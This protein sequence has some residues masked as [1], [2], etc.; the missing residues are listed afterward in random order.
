M[1]DFAAFKRWDVSQGRHEA[2]FSLIMRSYLS[3]LIKQRLP[4]HLDLDK[5]LYNI[6]QWSLKREID[7]QP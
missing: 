7:Q 1:G 6:C 5:K 3:N 4:S 2:C